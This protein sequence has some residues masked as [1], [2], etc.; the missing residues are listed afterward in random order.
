MPVTT[1]RTGQ[2]VLDHDAPTLVGSTAERLVEGGL[3]EWTLTGDGY[4]TLVGTGGHIYVVVAFTRT[5]HT[6]VTL[7]DVYGTSPEFDALC[8]QEQTS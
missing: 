5:Y 7:P 8:E 4:S 1:Y 2:E 6:D 3:A